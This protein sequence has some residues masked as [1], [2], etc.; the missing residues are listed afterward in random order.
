M[1]TNTTT[2]ARI[3][4]KSMQHL[5]MIAA[6]RG[7]SPGVLINK[8]LSNPKAL[9][10]ALA[11][12]DSGVKVHVRDGVDDFDG[13]IVDSFRVAVMSDITSEVYFFDP[14]NVSKTRSKS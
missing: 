5:R 6:K 9:R 2:T 7:T 8:I 13:V 11:M 10:A 4:R 3:N 12:I 14:E 1:D